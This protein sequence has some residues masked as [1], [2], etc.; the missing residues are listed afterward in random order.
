[1]G[2]KSAAGQHMQMFTGNAAYQDW[3]YYTDRVVYEGGHGVHG[4]GTTQS[5]PWHQKLRIRA[6]TTQHCARCAMISECSRDS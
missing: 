5:S 4:K 3:S 6:A 1:M 2:A